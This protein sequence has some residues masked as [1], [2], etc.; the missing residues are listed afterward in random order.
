VRPSIQAEGEGRDADARDLFHRAWDASTNDYEA[1]IAAHYLARHQT[2]AE[3][4]LHWNWVALD[5]AHASQ[6]ECVRP[7]LV[8]LHLNL[9]RCAEEE[10]AM[11]EAHAHYQWAL[12]ALLQVEEGCGRDMT[13]QCSQSVLK[14]TAG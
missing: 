12:A 9:G 10:G 6:D 8:S 14:R 3:D 7:F 2:T 4:T 1:C 11:T 5:R 13:A